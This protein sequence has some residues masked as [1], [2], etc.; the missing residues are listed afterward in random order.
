MQR[1][2]DVSFS[3]SS[4]GAGARDGIETREAAPPG[5]PNGAPDSSN[6]ARHHVPDP[7]FTII[8][9]AHEELVEAYEALAS[10]WRRK[11]VREYFLD[12]TIKRVEAAVNELAR[13][14]SDPKA[15]DAVKRDALRKVGEG[16]DYWLRLFRRKMGE[17]A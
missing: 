14:A 16:M 1:T 10:P 3:G 8:C 13:V 5:T 12:P 4:P 17:A 15:A 11:S 2:Q 9:R 6:E 7:A